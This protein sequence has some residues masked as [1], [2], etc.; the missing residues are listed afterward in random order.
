MA[1]HFAAKIP[2]QNYG[3]KILAKSPK[4]H[5]RKWHAKV[6]QADVST[7]SLYL[8]QLY[9]R[10]VN[11]TFYWHLLYKEN[12]NHTLY[13]SASRLPH[14]TTLLKVKQFITICILCCISHCVAS[15]WSIRVP[16]WDTWVKKCLSHFVLLGFKNTTFSSVDYS[17]NILI[18]EPDAAFVSFMMRIICFT[19]G[20]D[21]ICCLVQ[22]ISISWWSS[23]P[24]PE[25]FASGHEPE[26]QSCPD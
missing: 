6:W 22:P 2:C 13:C 8:G 19:L 20:F 25:A 3:T 9:K 4:W 24:D 11:H 5:I 1:W 21:T 16:I 12:V 15:I 14:F 10:N 18:Q 7:L 26:M 17:S 23:C